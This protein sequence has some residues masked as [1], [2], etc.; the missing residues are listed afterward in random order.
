[1]RR[2]FAR[3]R[4]FP[5]A[6]S[7]DRRYGRLSVKAIGLYPLMWANADDQ[8]RLVGDPEEIKYGVCP[9]ID[10]I[11]KADIP[12]LL[13]ELEANTLIKVYKTP[14]SLAIQM[15]DW[16]DP[17]LGQKLQWAWE[18]DYPPPDGWLDHLRYKKNAKEIVKLNWPVS[19]ED[20]GEDSGETLKPP[21]V[22]DNNS[23]SESSGE[24]RRT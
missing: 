12:E 19:G 3:A 24:K 15:L 13:K 2:A 7:T 22:S 9:N 23:S 4:M 6:Y 5:Q 21:Q 18:S 10:H 17:R 8:G 16:W 11:T 1:M 14:K 20:S